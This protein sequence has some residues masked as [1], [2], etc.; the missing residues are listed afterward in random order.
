MRY[1]ES[2]AICSG[3]LTIIFFYLLCA[4][5]ITGVIHEDK[6]CYYFYIPALGDL[7][8]TDALFDANTNWNLIPSIGQTV[9][10]MLLN[11]KFR[12][13]AK[14]LTDRENHKY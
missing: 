13:F 8:K 10:T 6:W 1:I 9:I 4:Y 14:T 12:E 5:N 11:Q 3:L 7:A 2:F